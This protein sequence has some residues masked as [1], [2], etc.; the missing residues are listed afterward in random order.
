MCIFALLFA[1]A[2][3]A[4][5]SRENWRELSLQE[6]RH[7]VEVKSDKHATW[8]YSG[9]DEAYH[10]FF[11]APGGAFSG[12][13][14]YVRIK[15]QNYDGIRHARRITFHGKPEHRAFVFTKRSNDGIGFVHLISLGIVDN[16]LLK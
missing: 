2:S 16:I 8:S 5:L 15:K 6:L 1:C 9:S 4:T 14:R 10:Y 7:E 12:K 3:P 11:R 13:Y